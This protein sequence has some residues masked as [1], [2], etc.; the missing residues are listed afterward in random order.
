MFL[1]VFV[2]VFVYVFVHTCVSACVSACMCLFVH[3][4]LHTYNVFV[5]VCIIDI[6]FLL[7]FFC[8]DPP[9]VLRTC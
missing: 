6:F 7:N 5:H 3:V 1:H 2:Y 8:R 4:F 9:L